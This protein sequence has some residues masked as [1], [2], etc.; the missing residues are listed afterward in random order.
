MGFINSFGLAMFLIIGVPVG[1]AIDRRTNKVRPMNLATT[2]RIAVLVVL[3]TLLTTGSLSPILLVTAALLIGF[4]DV[5]FTS[6]QSIIIPRLVHAKELR[7]AYSKLSVAGQSSSTTASFVGSLVVGIVG[8]AG[9]LVSS[10]LGY[11]S[12]L[13][14]Q[15]P[16]RRVTDG[17]T[18]EATAK[19][20]YREGWKI[21]R[22]TPALWILTCSTMMLNAGAMLGNTVLPVFLLRDL[23][24]SPAWY[25]AIGA[26]GAVRSIVGAA[27]TPKVAALLGLKNIRLYCGIF[28][29]LAVLLTAFCRQLP[30]SELLWVSMQSLLWNFLI[31]TAAVA[32]NEVLP[33]TIEPQHMGQVGATQRT[34]TLGIMPITALLGGLLGIFVGTF[35][36]LIIWSL[37]AIV[38]IIPILGRT[39][40]QSF[41]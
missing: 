33:R 11:L 34:L 18:D 31:A 6:A 7:S 29:G 35:W 19:I 36:L 30:G 13:L 26:I 10:I 40:L 17:S 14:L 27:A 21:L 4:A 32:G 20:S 41:D 12:S 24:I 16:L 22:S 23:A 38:S 9:L 39:E 1:Q 37:L 28:G 2:M 3:L 8:V 25:I 15:K 5:V